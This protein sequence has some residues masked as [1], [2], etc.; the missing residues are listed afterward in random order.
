MSQ[1]EEHIR[2]VAVNLITQTR[3]RFPQVTEPKNM[4][5]IF[6]LVWFCWELN[7]RLGK[8]WCR[9]CGILLVL[10]PFCFRCTM[11]LLLSS[12]ILL[13]L[14]PFVLSTKKLF[15]NGSL[16]HF[17]MLLVLA[18]GFYRLAILLCQNQWCSF[19]S[20]HLWHREVFKPWQLIKQNFSTLNELKYLFW[21]KLGS[22]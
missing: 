12:T 10:I 22:H 1:R 7:S 8:C 5:L 13:G 21:C 19:D 17:P 20:H 15:G 3:D 16:N 11:N 2:D 14:S 6:F 9:F 4:I 18:R